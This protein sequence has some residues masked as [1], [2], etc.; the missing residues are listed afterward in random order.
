MITDFSEGIALYRVT[1][2]FLTSLLEL[3]ALY[4]VEENGRSSLILSWKCS[5]SK[6]Q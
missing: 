1:L 3:Q 5:G 2:W 4:G 6:L